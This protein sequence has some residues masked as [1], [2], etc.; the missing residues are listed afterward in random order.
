MS[1]RK[2][3]ATLEVI[4]TFAYAGLIA[5][6]IRTF[7]FEPFNIPS[8]S[9]MP[10]LLVGDFLFVSKYSY[11]YSRYSLPFGLPLIPG[12]VWSQLPERGDVAV[13]KL[14]SDTKTDYIK[15]IVGLPDDVIQLRQGV[16]HVNGAPVKRERIADY[17]VRNAS[18]NSR[19]LAQYVE[20]FDNGRS[21]DIVEESEN[22]PSDSTKPYTVPEGH[23]FAMGDNRD[24][25][26]DSRMI[27]FVP[28]ENLVGRAEFLWFS[29]D[30]AFLEFWKWPWTIRFERLFD[31]IE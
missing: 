9:M 24:N 11:G 27:G 26:Q 3:R 17:V 10:T 15:R 28:I 19:R 7:A 6:V 25:S 23:V 22:G 4:K 5:L 31:G 2:S 13:F 29:I 16:L 14:P 18:G 12:R 30:G 1:K 20:T 8:G 21:H